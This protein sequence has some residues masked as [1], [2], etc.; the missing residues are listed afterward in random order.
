MDFKIPKFDEL[1]DRLGIGEASSQA[2]S[3]SSRLAI[4]AMTPSI[5]AIM[6]NTALTILPITRWRTTR[7]L[8]A[9]RRR[10]PTRHV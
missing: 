8:R 4:L 2:G 5:M 10:C 9:S 6:A 3:R 1:K 7:L